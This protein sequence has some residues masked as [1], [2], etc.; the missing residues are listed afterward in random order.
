MRSGEEGMSGGISNRETKAFD[1]LIED[2]KIAF[3]MSNSYLYQISFILDPLLVLS[4][5]WILF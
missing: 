5:P 3:Y 4:H 2:Y 1:F